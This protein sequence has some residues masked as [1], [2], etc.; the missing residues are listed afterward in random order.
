MKKEAARNSVS[1]ATRQWW[2]TVW[3]R[4]SR[5]PAEQIYVNEMQAVEI[6]MHEIYLHRKQARCN[7]ILNSLLS[8]SRVKVFFSLIPSYLQFH[9][10][11]LETSWARKKFSI[12]GDGRDT[13]A[14]FYLFKLLYGLQYKFYLL[15]GR[16]NNK[17]HFLHFSFLHFGGNIGKSSF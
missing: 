5:G 11:V 14:N 13:H 12:P 10:F 8:C 4:S 2:N 6:I 7:F 15:F 3:S 16:I 9:S 17:K 1:R